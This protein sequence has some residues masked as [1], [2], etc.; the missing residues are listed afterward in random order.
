TFTNPERWVQWNATIDAATARSAGYSEAVRFTSCAIGNDPVLTTSVNWPGYVRGRLLSVWL[1]PGD[2]N[3]PDF[4]WEQFQTLVYH[5]T[6]AVAGSLTNF[7]N[8][9]DFNVDHY[10][11]LLGR[12][13]V[14]VAVR[15]SWRYVGG[16]RL[17]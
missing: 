6:P 10:A 2:I 12:L 3:I 7:P 4:R 13:P 5:G 14:T 11:P 17:A 1:D 16:Q 9:K 15:D 8:V